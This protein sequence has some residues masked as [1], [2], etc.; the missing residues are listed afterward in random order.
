MVPRRII[1]ALAPKQ[2]R[3]LLFLTLHIGG[4][5]MREG[6][7]RWRTCGRHDR[8][9]EDVPSAGLGPYGSFLRLFLSDLR[10]GH[11]Y[12]G[13]FKEISMADKDFRRA[14][15]GFFM[16][17]KTL[18]KAEQGFLVA[19]QLLFTAEKPFDCH[20]QEFFMAEKPLFTA[21]IRH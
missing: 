15:E 17:L 18:F 2:R 3:A 12:P 11:A 21:V 1:P 7:E 5:R 9:E 20:D 8:R 4:A 13:P 6:R 19:L 14:V 10:R 16:A